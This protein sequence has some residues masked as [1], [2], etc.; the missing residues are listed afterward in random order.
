MKKKEVEC[1]EDRK[2]EE[3][4]SSSCHSEVHLIFSVTSSSDIRRKAI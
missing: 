3:I 4:V 1:V 2:E